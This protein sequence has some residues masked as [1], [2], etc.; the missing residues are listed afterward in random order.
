MM[1][2][3]RNTYIPPE[4]RVPGAPGYAQGVVPPVI[5]QEESSS[6]GSR[7]GKSKRRFNPWANLPDDGCPYDD[8]VEN[9]TYKGLPVLFPNGDAA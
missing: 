6:S 1:P 8:I 4:L 9:A 7:K 3:P 2:R 5:G